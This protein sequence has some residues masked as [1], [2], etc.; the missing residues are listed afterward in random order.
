VSYPNVI[1]AD[2]RPSFFCTPIPE[3]LQ[4]PSP[5]RD[6]AVR[7]MARTLAGMQKEAV[8]AST[9]RGRAWRLVSD[10]GPALDG[11]QEAPVPLAFLTAGLV[12]SWTEE[13]VL[14]AGQRGVDVSGL[15]VQL[16]NFY[17]T[18]GS[19][20]RGTM[21]AGSLAPILA[22][23]TESGTAPEQLRTLCADA[24]NASP[25]NGLVR[26][27]HTSL[28]TLTVNGD[29]VP[30]GKA[31]GLQRLPEPDAGLFERLVVEGPQEAD[32]LISR[33]PYTGPKDPAGDV[34]SSGLREDRPKRT[35]DVRGICTLRP[36]GVK[37][38]DVRNAHRNDSPVWRFLTRES[39]EQGGMPTA[40]DAATLVS[41]GIAFCFMTQ[42]GRYARVAKQSV[43]DYRVVQ[44]LH[45]S[46][47]G[48][49]TGR[50]G[51]ADAVESY[52]YLRTDED[53]EAARTLVRM[54]RQTCY[55]HALCE[56]DLR[57]RLR[58]GAQV[59]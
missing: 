2:P 9:G 30:T 52:V 24:V 57:P 23:E 17:T 29:E 3:E 34:P 25:V 22:V 37:V 26:G 45:F 5:R 39:S 12:A 47:P 56:T 58:V 42:L 38:V 10:E 14:L 59:A 31:S 48:S 55:L 16:D 32:Q 4:P 28:F 33:L 51:E 20:L 18:E 40:P 43:A 19:A 50:P 53:A 8:V 41:A 13:M 11:H 27:V 15:C 6:M 49:R 36:D 21:V 35:L 44:D 54:G 1:G 7:A 46:G